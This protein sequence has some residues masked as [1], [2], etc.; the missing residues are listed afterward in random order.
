MLR[1]TLFKNFKFVYRVS[2]WVRKHLTHGGM[3]VIG[4]IIF[5]G[6]FGI[7][8]RQTLSFQ[9]FFLLTSLLLI[10][11]LSNL[12]FRGQFTIKRKLPEYCT[13]GQSFTYRIT[14]KNLTNKIQ[15]SLML[16]EELISPVPTYDEFMY[17]AKSDKSRNWFDRFV[18]YPRWLQLIQKKRGASIPVTPL[19]LIPAND[20]LTTNITVTPVHRGYINFK[21]STLLRPDPAGLFNACKS[22]NEKDSLLVLPKRYPVPSIPLPGKRKYQQRGII[23]ASS[24]GDSQEFISLRDYRPGDPLRNI[25]WRSFAKFSKPL[26]K[27]YQDEF[28][29]RTGIVLDTF[30]IDIPETIFEEAVSVA[31]SFI[32]S[33]QPNDSILDLMFVGLNAHCFTS[34][35]NVSNKRHMLEILACVKTCHDKPFSDLSTFVS[36]HAHRLSSLVCILLNWDRSRQDLIK[37]LKIAGIPILVFVITQEPDNV[38][39]DLGPM[40]DT[41]DLFHVLHQ[42]KIEN[43][44]TN[45]KIR[46]QT[47]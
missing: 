23:L 10:A 20:N 6:I 16:M 26:V 9:I 35:R 8:T 36:S 30:A 41:P 37:T 12:I 21:Q 7:D 5:S 34:G 17:A 27:E 24:V 1:R 45:L 19:D 38:S 29:V 46:F 32:N 11:I 39:N 25:H 31:A 33:P 22:I 42:G 44:L 15:E 2:Q 18:G 47:K 43:E 13:V 3:L 28:F 40:T 4:G 14:V